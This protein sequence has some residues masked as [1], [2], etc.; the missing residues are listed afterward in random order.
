MDEIHEPGRTLPVVATVD[1]AVC[2]G[3]PAGLMA[4]VAAARNGARTLLIERYGF[5]GGMATA[6]LVGP[7]CKFNCQGQAIVGGIP[8]ELMASMAD[9]GGAILGLPSGNVPF[10]A[11]IYKLQAQRLAQEAGV[12][13]LLHSYVCG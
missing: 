8:A 5:L 9:H 3:G 11:E 13:M 7:I 10:D 4:A 6:G 12:Q 1:V 2:G